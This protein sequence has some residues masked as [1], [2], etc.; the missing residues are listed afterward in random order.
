M[1]ASQL[2]E[3]PAHDEDTIA[4]QP[5]DGFV[6]RLRQLVL[7]AGSASALARKAG[8][9]PGGLS[10]YLNGGDPSRRV[11]IALAKATGADIGWLAS[12]EGPMLNGPDSEDDEDV[13]GATLR[14]L[15]YFHPP[16]SGEHEVTASH[17]HQEFTS[18]AFCYRWLNAR[19]LN[20]QNLAVMQ[21]RGGSMSP[22]LSH[23]DTVL[24]DTSDSLVEDDRIYLLENAGNLLLRRLQIELGGQLRVRADNPQ[25]RE[26]V[27]S[28]DQLTIHGRVVWL[29]AL[30]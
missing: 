18:Q 25:H 27:V 23:G 1:S 22:T 5:D 26:F 20:K 28:P 2:T 12:G 11:L 29:G 3:L 8:I 21:V 9:S 13:P 16:A 15:P 14:L 10:R 30:V 4:D 17:Q 7:R 19:G 6:A 24:I